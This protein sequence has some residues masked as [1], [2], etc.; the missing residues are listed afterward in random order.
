MASA[1]EGLSEESDISCIGSQVTLP[2]DVRTKHF[3]RSPPNQGVRRIIRRAHQGMTCDDNAV[4]QSST[5]EHAASMGNP[6]TISNDYVSLR[7]LAMNF[8]PV[9][10]SD[11]DVPC[12]Q[13][14]MTNP[15]AAL[16]H[17]GRVTGYP[18]IRFQALPTDVQRSACGDENSH[19]IA[20]RKIAVDS[21]H[22]S[23]VYDDSR[24][25]VSSQ[26]RDHSKAAVQ[27]QLGTWLLDYIEREAGMLT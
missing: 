5:L 1:C 27:N 9:R 16:D 26:K 7:C 3:R 6:H 17:D 21:Q 25:L 8:V 12:T 19:A 15:H 4:P 2:G 13:E 24:R 14:V 18:R 20:N 10:I 23:L 11:E 22:T